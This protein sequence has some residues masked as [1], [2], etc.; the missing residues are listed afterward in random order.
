VA[1]RASTALEAW[2]KVVAVNVIHYVNS[3]K[4]D[5]EEGGLALDEEVTV[6]TLSDAGVRGEYN[7]HW[8]EGKPFA[9]ALQ[10]NEER[11][12]NVDLQALHENLGAAPPYNRTREGTVTR[13]DV[14]DDVEA[15]K[16][17]LESAYGFNS[18]NVD[19]W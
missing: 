6:E 14:I 19:A 11:N 13:Q 10:F 18:S 1:A 9:W 8:G 12:P 15:V 4:S 16:S 17:Q 5:L 3:M 7:E 2:E